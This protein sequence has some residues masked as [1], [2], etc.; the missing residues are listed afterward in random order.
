MSQVTFFNFSDY[1]K[2]HFKLNY[3]KCSKIYE[4]SNFLTGDNDGAA[5]VTTWIDTAHWLADT[6]KDSASK[7]SIFNWSQ[8]SINQFE[9]RF[10]D[11]CGTPTEWDHEWHLFPLICV[12]YLLLITVTLLF[13]FIITGLVRRCIKHGEPAKNEPRTNDFKLTDDGENKNENDEM[14]AFRPTHC[15]D[16]S[17]IDNN[18]T[19]QQN[20]EEIGAIKPAGAIK[21]NRILLQHQTYLAVDSDMNLRPKQVPVVTFLRHTTDYLFSMMDKL[22][23]ENRRSPQRSSPTRSFTDLGIGP[24]YNAMSSMPRRPLRRTQLRS[25]GSSPHLNEQDDQSSDPLEKRAWEEFIQKIVMNNNIPFD[26]DV[27]L[28]MSITGSAQSRKLLQFF[29]NQGSM[30]IE[31]LQVSNLIV[32]YC[33]YLLSK[34]IEAN[35]SLREIQFENFSLIGSMKKG[36]KV[37][38]ANQFDFRMKFHGTNFYVYEIFDQQKSED[39]PPGKIFLRAKA[40]QACSEPRCLK[41]VQ[42]N[43]QKYTCLSSKSVHYLAEEMIDRALQNLYTG[44]KSLIDRLPFRMQRSA[45]GNLVL[46]ID[47]RNVIGLG[48]QEI[49]VRIIPAIFLPINGWYQPAS[50][51]ASAYTLT[52]QEY[53]CKVGRGKE[54]SPVPLGQSDALWTLDL[55]NL[56]ELFLRETNKKMKAA[57]VHSCHTTCIKILKVLFSSLLRKSLLDRGELSSNMIETVIYYLL[58]ESTPDQWVFSL[59]SDRVSDAYLYLK[60]ALESGRLPNF[61]MNNP[62]LLKKMPFLY[63]Y[64]F[65]VKGKQQNLLTDSRLETID[66]KLN[67]MHDRIRDTGLEDCFQDTYSPD[68][69]EYEFFIYS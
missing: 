55:G 58:L 9:P 40:T 3:W 8:K 18:A 54:P 64:P 14:S 13:C 50:L 1:Y 29:I 66:K 57:G 31:Q 38:T 4:E 28:N 19:F 63:S 47:T 44:T 25:R 15:L 7:L 61:F 45:T 16:Y 33:L 6:I 12:I 60:S 56:E 20:I 17:D 65:L 67:F 21:G 62:H 23:L 41:L 51:Y 48:L 22:L 68:T 37:S 46:S 59:I 24:T 69:W 26:F 5:N 34:E 10:V 2:L 30:K 43:Q 32:N 35:S 49:K 27:D 52:Q 39:I 11:P 53:K 42:I 36:V